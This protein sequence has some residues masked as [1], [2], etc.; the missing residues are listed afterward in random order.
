[1]LNKSNLA[2]F[3]NVLP[4]SLFFPANVQLHKTTKDFGSGRWVDDEKINIKMGFK[5]I[6]KD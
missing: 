3:L 4:W 5:E 6:V 2:A 1:M